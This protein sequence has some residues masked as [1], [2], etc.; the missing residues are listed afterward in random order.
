MDE[1]TV[2][3]FWAK[4]DKVNGPVH[5]LHGQCWMWTAGR[6]G[7]MGYGRFSLGGRSVRSHRMARMIATG[8][9][10]GGGWVLHRC[11]NPLCVNP[12]HLFLGT[13]QDNI[14]DMVAKNRHAFGLRLPQ[15]RISDE[16]VAAIR[17]ASGTQADIGRRYGV[18]Q[19]TVSMIRT[20]HRRLRRPDDPGS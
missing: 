1:K 7:R 2:A 5:P 11:D 10:P 16:E 3:R 15:T 6:V 20:G 4:V 17:A 13:P 8:S 9:D 12:G 19:Q 18:S 14:A